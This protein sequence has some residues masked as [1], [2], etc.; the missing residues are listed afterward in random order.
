MLWLVSTCLLK[1][2][3]FVGGLTSQQHASISQ[4][5]TCIDSCM[6]WRTETKVAD[7]TFYLYESQYTDTW[8][9]IPSADPVVPGAWQGSN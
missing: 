8:P 1:M 9:T 4:R 5:Q 2:L 7:Q 3:L 6:C